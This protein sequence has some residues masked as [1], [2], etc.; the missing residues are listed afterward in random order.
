MKKNNTGF[1][2][3]EVL[4]TVAILGVLLIVVVPQ[5]SKI[6]ERQVLKNGAEEVV[7]SLDKAR[8]QTLASLNSD[9]YG[10]R[11]ESARVIIF[12]GTTYSSGAAGNEIID[13]V[14]PATITN[15]TLGGVSSTSGAM[16]FNRLT[17]SPSATGTITVATPN[18]SKIITI[19]A[20]G[21]GSIN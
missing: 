6:K 15:V 21:T 9:V 13:I 14:S 4:I 8:S 18:L 1:T 7:S 10:V 12:K 2:F 11:F 5:F 19:S 17:G 16:Y 3:I 20:T